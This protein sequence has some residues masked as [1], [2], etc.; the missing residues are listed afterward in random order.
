MPP[1]KKKFLFVNRKAPYGTIHA[2][3]ALEA[4]LTG[5]AFEQRISILFL[6]DGVFPLLKEQN[7]GDI[8]LKDFSPTYN[9]LSLYGVENIYVDEES[10]IERGIASDELSIKVELK[11]TKEVCLIMEQQDVIFNF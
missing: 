3:E 5:A 7:S 8:G 1:Q 9:A 10:L 6:D 2:H 11:T 4:I